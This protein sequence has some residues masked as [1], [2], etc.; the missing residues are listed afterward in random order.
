[1]TDAAEARDT[2]GP[3]HMCGYV[4]KLDNSSMYYIDWASVPNKVLD[5]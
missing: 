3:I 5:T 4:L 1:M 2:S